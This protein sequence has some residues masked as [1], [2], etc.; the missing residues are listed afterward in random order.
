MPGHDSKEIV[1]IGVKSLFLINHSLN[2]GNSFAQRSILPGRPSI[3]PPLSRLK[4]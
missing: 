1:G 2:L 3:S 4:I